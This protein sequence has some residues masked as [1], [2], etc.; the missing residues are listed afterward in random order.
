MAND[1]VN[2]SAGDTTGNQ[3]IGRP[4][5]NTGGR[6]ANVSQQLDTTS[7]KESSAVADVAAQYDARFDDPRYYAG[8]AAT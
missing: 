5:V 7:N 1:I 4:T 8:D 2:A 6:G 3:V